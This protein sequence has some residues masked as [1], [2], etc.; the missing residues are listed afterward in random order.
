VA[1]PVTTPVVGDIAAI[2]EGDI[3]HMPPEEGSLRVVLSPTHVESVPT[4]GM[5]VGLTVITAV[6]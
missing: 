4:I 5:G 6:V 1:T 3:S 2:V